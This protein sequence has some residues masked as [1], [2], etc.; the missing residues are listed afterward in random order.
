MNESDA[1]GNFGLDIETNVE[2]IGEDSLIENPP[3]NWVQYTDEVSGN[4]YFYNEA[5]GESRWIEVAVCL[6]EKFYDDDGNEF[7]HHKVSPHHLFN[8]QTNR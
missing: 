2:M 5:T 6:W 4:P 3:D 8:Y 1:D 7:Y